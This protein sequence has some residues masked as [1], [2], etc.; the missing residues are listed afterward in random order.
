[1]RTQE[2]YNEKIEE[3]TESLRER[4]TELGHQ[5]VQ[6]QDRYSAIDAASI[7]VILD[8]YKHQIKLLN[9]FSFAIELLKKSLQERN[10]E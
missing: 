2:F 1:M 4:V 8:D 3:L 7:G 6:D 10:Q 5:I 9:D